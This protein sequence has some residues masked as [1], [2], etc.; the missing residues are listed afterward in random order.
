[1]K[2]KELIKS[3][4]AFFMC[5]PTFIN[6]I[7]RELSKK[8]PLEPLGKHIKILGGYAFKS[9][10]YK[11]EGIPIIRIS[12]FQD[13]KLD[14]SNVKYYEENPE[15]D[16]YSL[17]EGDIIIALTGGTIGKLGIVQ[18]GLGKVYLNQRVGKFYTLHPKEFYGKY[19]YWLARGIQEKVRS[20]GYGGAQP[21][22]SGKQIEELEFSIP[23]KNLQEKIVG[24]LEDLKNN[25]VQ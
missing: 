12:D 17:I 16:K 3:N 13:E 22:I 5:L 6:L 25:T 9:S 20:F 19:I 15:Y 4:F 11:L 14:L 21:N 8:Y 10:Q 23:N 24:F 18:N 1:M 2:G 7:N